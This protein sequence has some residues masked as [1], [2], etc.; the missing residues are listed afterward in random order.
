M[1]NVSIKYFP[2]GDEAVIFNIEID[3]IHIYIGDLPIRKESWEATK[4]KVDDLIYAYNK[5]ET[6]KW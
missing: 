6:G 4:E 2:D 3:D 5:A 1:S